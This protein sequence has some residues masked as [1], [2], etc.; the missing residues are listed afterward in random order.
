MNFPA[1]SACIL[2]VPLTLI[3]GQARRT[4]VSTQQ[5]AQHKTSSAPEETG[6]QVFAT[7]CSRCHA[8]PMS[9]SPRVTGTVI[10]HMRARARLSQRDEQLLLKYLA[11]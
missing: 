11:P 6:E 10:M 3:A 5:A 4:A 7:N 8:A 1:L 9:L 2:L